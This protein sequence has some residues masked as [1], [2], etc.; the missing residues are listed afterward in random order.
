MTLYKKSSRIVCSLM[1]VL[2][3]AAGC[4]K[5]SQP[6][7]ESEIANSVWEKTEQGESEES[8]WFFRENS[9]LMN[10]QG[11]NAFKGKRELDE[12]NPRVL[13]LEL[14]IKSGKIARYTFS[15]DTDGFLVSDGQYLGAKSLSMENICLKRLPGSPAIP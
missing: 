8:Q 7:K 6:I 15:K 14:A 3:L 5:S 4:S 11:A 1:A 12:N 10:I 13:L 9:T 2:Y